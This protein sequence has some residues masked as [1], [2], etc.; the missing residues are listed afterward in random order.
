M[1]IDS[2]VIIVIATVVTIFALSTCLAEW[3]DRR[4]PVMPLLILLAMLGVFAYVHVVVRPGGLTIWSIPEAFVAV[5][6]KLL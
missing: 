1:F 6:A 5:A 2:N 3:A 4:T